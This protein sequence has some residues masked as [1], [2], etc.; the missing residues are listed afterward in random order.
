MIHP[1]WRSKTGQIIIG[2][3]GT[4]VGMVM[5]FGTLF[6]ILAFCAICASTNLASLSLMQQIEAEATPQDAAQPPSTSPEE[7]DLL[8]VKLGSLA[9]KVN[10]V[11]YTTIVVTPTP[12][13]PRPM[14]TAQTDAINL[15][16]GP[17]TIYPKIGRLPR[18]ES[19][20]IV[21][22]SGDGGWWLV[23][24]PNGQFAWAANDAVVTAHLDNS[25]PVVTIPALLVQASA[26]NPSTGV[27][28]GAVVAD[29]VPPA[30]AALPASSLPQ[31]AGSPTAAANASRRYVQDTLG[32]KQFVRRL[33]L[34]TVSESYSPDG[35]QIAITERIKLYTIT[36][37][38]GTVRTLLADDDTITLIGGVVWSPDGQYLAFVADKVADC[39][40]C[41]QV[42]LV[43]L[44]NGDISYL[45][46]PPSS[47]VD[48][49]RWTQDGRLLVTSFSDDLAE[50]AAYIYDTTGQGQ[51]ATGT[52]ILSASHD[53]Q[54]WF[55]WL[56]GAVWQVGSAAPP[57]SY[58]EE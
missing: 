49:P 25:I 22:R 13:P 6:V 46:P 5:T 19:L 34:P 33:L 16:S 29:F 50:G 58:Y 40:Y 38:G 10:A 43:R 41:R 11:Q 53:G 3:C 9:E 31:P 54:K 4:Q 21:G 12:T 17:D 52:Y 48:R 55:P 8:R 27:S 7:I 2:S 56:P 39:Q 37:D 35:Q 24:A 1:F 57:D 14:I 20:Q 23:S 26:N 18:G 44:S 42:G 36:A 32:Y 30:E 28:T 45:E 47:S 51:P 15:R